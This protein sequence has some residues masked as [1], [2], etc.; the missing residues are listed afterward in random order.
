MN[1]SILSGYLRITVGIDFYSRIFRHTNHGRT[2]VD[3]L[4]RILEMEQ[5]IYKLNDRI[6]TL[7]KRLEKRDVETINLRTQITK[8]R[9]QL[10]KKDN[11]L[12]EQKEHT[13][14]S[15]GFLIIILHY[16]A[17]FYSNLVLTVCILIN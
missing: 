11:Q 16:S 4:R 8:L 12:S 13:T 10:R 9:K 3:S 14:L 17:F 7:K 6:S 2:D 1:S 15:V 5:I